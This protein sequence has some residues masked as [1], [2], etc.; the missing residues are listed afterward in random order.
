MVQFYHAVTDEELFDI[1]T[2][3]LSDIESFVKEIGAFLE[4]Y[5]E[6]LTE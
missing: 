4:A 2:R 1:L 3:H 5:R 6:R